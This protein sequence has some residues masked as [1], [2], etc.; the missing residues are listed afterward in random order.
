MRQVCFFFVFLRAF[1][2]ADCAGLLRNSPGGFQED[3]LHLLNDIFLRRK[4]SV[5]LEQNVSP[6]A[7][8]Q[9]RG[10]TTICFQAHWKHRFLVKNICLH[11]FSSH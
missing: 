4:F 5:M 2:A 1:L 11:G 8:E 9:G 7:G 10:S 6:N 3:L